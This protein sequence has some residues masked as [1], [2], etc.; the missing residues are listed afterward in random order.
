M[1]IWQILL[2][3]EVEWPD[4]NFLFEILLDEPNIHVYKINYLVFS[5]PDL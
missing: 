4:H 1:V 2:G 3:G 5:E